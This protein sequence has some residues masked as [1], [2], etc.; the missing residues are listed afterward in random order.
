MDL[1]TWKPH[2][3]ILKP[4]GEPLYRA[5]KEVVDA[6]GNPSVPKKRNTLELFEYLFQKI[7]LASHDA[8]CTWPPALVDDD[9]DDD[10]DGATVVVV[11]PATSGPEDAEN[12][13]SGTGGGS[14]EVE[15]EE[16]P[17][18]LALMTVTPG[19]GNALKIL[20]FADAKPGE[21]VDADAVAAALE[22]RAYAA[23]RKFFVKNAGVE[24]IQ[25]CTL[26]GA[27]VRCWTVKRD[28]EALAG[29]WTPEQHGKFSNYVDVG[30]DENRA[31]L[32]LTISR[33]MGNLHIRTAPWF[34]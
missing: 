2:G 32:E 15:E 6:W 16:K 26:L 22:A 7:L 31:V 11:D 20:C 14:V 8:M 27:M 17:C 12:T 19:D 28:A 5:A 1:R 9:D 4:A 21:G 30:V 25:A 13:D 23:C 3:L 10:D 18:D 24:Q 29:L 33:M 34:D